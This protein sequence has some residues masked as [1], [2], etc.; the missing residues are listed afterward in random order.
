MGNSTTVDIM[1]ILK[2]KHNMLS[3]S[4]SHAYS[5]KDVDSACKTLLESSNCSNSTIEKNY[6]TLENRLNDINNPDKFYHVPLLVIE[7]LDEDGN[8]SMA[9]TISKRYISNTAKNFNC[10]SLVRIKNSIDS[11]SITESQKET[12]LEGISEYIAVDR[13]IKN[14]NIISKSADIESD[15]IKASK[16]GEAAIVE[17]TKNIVDNFMKI[18]Y[19]KMNVSIEE[20][21][22]VLGINNIDYDK[23]KLLKL[24]TEAYLIEYDEEDV[25]KIKKVV[26]NNY[27]YDD[28]CKQDAEKIFD[29]GENDTIENAINNF[30]ARRMDS[31][32]ELAIDIGNCS[33]AGIINNIS[34]AFDFYLKY[35][36]THR[37]TVSIDT[38]RECI[39][40]IFSTISDRIKAG[41]NISQSDIDAI[42][43]SIKDYANNTIQMSKNCIYAEQSDIM[44]GFCSVI[45]LELEQFYK[46][47]D[48]LYDQKNI[49]NI[50]AANIA[51]RESIDLDNFNKLYKNRFIANIESLKESID[52]SI[53]VNSDISFG[54]I[55]DE[56]DLIANIGTDNK[57]DVCVC[58]CNC[59]ESVKDLL[60]S[61]CD[62]FNN[63]LISAGDFDTKAYYVVV[64]DD[65]AEV[66]IKDNKEFVLTPEEK[67]INEST[68]SSEELYYLET[69]NTLGSAF[70]NMNNKADIYDKNFATDHFELY[71]EALSYLGVSKDIIQLERNKVSDNIFNSLIESGAITSDQDKEFLSENDKLYDISNEYEPKRHI[72]LDIKLEALTYVASIL[73]APEIKKADIKKADIKKA[74]AAKYEKEDN[75]DKDVEEADKSKLN[76]PEEK[77]KKKGISF[78]DIKLGLAGLK[79]KLG[80]MSAKEKDL[81]KNI[82]ATA[83]HFMKAIHDGLVSD[84]REAIIKGSVIPSFSRLI[85][86]CLALVAIGGVSA[87]LV[88][89]ILPAVI[90]AFGGFAISKKLTQK[91]RM[92]MLDD[93]EVELDIVEKEIATAESRNQ[94]KKYRA[95]LKY[96]KD[97]Q[98]QY[99]RIKY[100]VRIGKDI[101]PNSATG[102]YKPG[103]D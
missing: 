67:K 31:L 54:D 12:I 81:S 14:H 64:S 34:I 90:V 23:S 76:L 66:H 75:N 43:S 37:E 102:V 59:N 58:L 85:K 46:D 20:S 101:L 26:D 68:F 97:L 79:G 16:F 13:I 73:E 29:K 53:K 11:Y 71:T 56:T 25:D 36:I 48:F 38:I 78:N 10:D 74:D 27:C 95:L 41:E 88:G 83:G 2:Y 100:N 6:I 45:G 28:E 87:A 49:S 69:M 8:I 94:M 50:T 91:E 15:I 99:Q 80:D 55:K 84:R 63:K 39:R 47:C 86:D 35:L 77:K 18:P 92:L 32:T 3:E 22:Y 17:A 52:D 51:A 7:K 9:D 5:D 70:Y 1:T 44:I 62:K 98:R 57:L 82:D 4:V 60:S 33:I 72:P 103:G 40:L 19:Q 21:F 93:I 30:I 42:K 24:F 61:S 89:T 65:L 96:K